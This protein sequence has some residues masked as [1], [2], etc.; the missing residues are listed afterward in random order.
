MTDQSTAAETSI[1]EAN[2]ASVD[3]QLAALKNKAD[4]LGVSYSPRI[5]IDALRAKINE[6][7]AEPKEETVPEN[8]PVGGGVMSEDTRKAA[9]RRKM[10]KEE[11]RLVRVRITNMNPQKKD[12]SGEIFTVCNKFLGI[13]KKFVPYGEAT[14]N[15]YHIPWIIYKQLKARKFQS[16][17]T[18]QVNGQIKVTTRDVPEFA[19]E[20]LPSLSEKELK[21][22]AIQQ[23]A[24]QGMSDDD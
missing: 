12:L 16:I 21:Q 1:P 24:A 17:K 15:G 14:D 2:G 23:A 20:I 11:L 4:T 3:E 10:Q 8:V 5:G 6:A 19:L 7:M 22:L 18:R 13:V 9:K